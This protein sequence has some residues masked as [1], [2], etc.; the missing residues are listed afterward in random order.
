MNTSS[1][2]RTNDPV[3][4]MVKV[5]AGNVPRPVGKARPSSYRLGPPSTPPAAIAASTRQ[6]TRAL[7][8]AADTDQEGAAPKSDST[9]GST[10]PDSASDSVPRGSAPGRAGVR[11]VTR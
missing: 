9:S 5:V 10:D 11:D 6:E 1:S 2:A 4:L 8:G 7:G 3:T